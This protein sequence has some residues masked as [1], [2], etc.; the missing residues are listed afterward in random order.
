MPYTVEQH[1]EWRKNNLDKL[2]VYENRQTARAKAE[3]YKLLGY[4]CARC[5]F[6][7]PRA[8]Q[9]DHVNGNGTELRL[10]SKIRSTRKILY[11]MRKVGVDQFQILCANCNWIKRVEN[12]ES[13]YA[14]S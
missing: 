1:R 14:I 9:I 7:D 2:K 8:L 12:K 10:K 6:D 3:I 4:K 13:K 11:Y 5:G